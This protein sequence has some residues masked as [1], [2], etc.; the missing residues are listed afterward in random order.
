MYESPESRRSTDFQ[1]G[2]DGYP[3]TES[4]ESNWTEA[5]IWA[6]Q[7]EAFKYILGVFYEGSGLMLDSKC[8]RLDAI[9][10]YEQMAM[11][12]P[13]EHAK[14][15]MKRPAYYGVLGYLRHKNI[16]TGEEIGRG[17]GSENGERTEE[18]IPPE[19]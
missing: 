16:D 4:L 1:M 3:G 18:G 19:L 14:E 13:S 10:G 7:R 2:G 17:A 8:Q 9:S 11:K 15:C 5:I 12:P 6:S